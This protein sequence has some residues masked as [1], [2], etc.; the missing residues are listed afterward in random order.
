DGTV[1]RGGRGGAQRAASWP[2]RPPGPLSRDRARPPPA[3][4]ATSPSKWGR[5]KGS[6]FRSLRRYAPPPPAS[7]GGKKVVSS[8][9]SGATR[10]LPQQVGEAKRQC[11]PAP[12]ALRATSPSKWG[13]QKGSV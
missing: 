7:G 4:R 10:H 13:R 3:L 6:V 8:G 1:L 12:P 5:Q 2:Q 9:P 11:L